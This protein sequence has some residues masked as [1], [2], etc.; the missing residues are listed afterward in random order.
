MA[1]G[2]EKLELFLNKILSS[3]DIIEFV[4]FNCD[5]CIHP[6]LFLE[7]II[8]LQF[9]FLS[10]CF[11]GK[12]IFLYTY[13]IGDSKLGPYR[14]FTLFFLKKEIFLLKQHKMETKTRQILKKNILFFSLLFFKF[15]FS[16]IKI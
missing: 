14:T 10:I 15:Y 7:S 16:K 6:L 13:L 8:L 11:I 9:S 5:Q 12:L 4:F 1:I 3:N 2:F